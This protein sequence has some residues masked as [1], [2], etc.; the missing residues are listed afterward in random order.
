MEKVINIS[1]KKI[2]DNDRLILHTKD[3]QYVLKRDV[4]EFRLNFKSNTGQT[5]FFI[6]EEN[7]KY[8]FDLFSVEVILI[9]EFIVRVEEI[10]KEIKKEIEEKK[11]E[12]MQTI[13]KIQIE[14]LREELKKKEYENEQLKERLKFVIE[15]LQNKVLKSS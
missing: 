2:K 12:E 14:H 8:F 1:Y 15:L 9:E 5:E 6:I 4:S 13:E 10:E 11:L 7:N 3:N